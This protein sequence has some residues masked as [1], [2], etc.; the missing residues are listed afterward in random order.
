MMKAIINGRIF[1]PSGFVLNKALVFNEK[2]R[3]FFE[4]SEIPS[5]V[6][7]INAENNYVLPGFVDI[8][9]HG[10]G[11]CDFLDADIDSVKRIIKVH[12]LHGTTSLLAT[13]LTCPDEV[14]LRGLSAVAEVIECP[15]K[16]GAEIL[17]IHLEGPYLSACAKG[18]QAVSNERTPSMCEMENI[19]KASKG[20]IIRWDAAPELD[21]IG[22]FANW[23][24]KKGVLA[25]IA[26]SSA[27]AVMGSA[28]T[29]G[30]VMK[31]SRIT[32]TSGSSSSFR[33]RCSRRPGSNTGWGALAVKS[34]APK[35]KMA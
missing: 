25:S 17:G 30:P 2:I 15:D 24:N 10:G 29:P 13:T 6:E 28:A 1:T 14:L 19:W 3:G 22:M 35:S 11:G 9:I 5:D 18:A 31:S 23:L 26:H 16:Y 27:N 34:S 32:P 7:I 21:N 8:H 12:A 4:Y 33:S 20:Y